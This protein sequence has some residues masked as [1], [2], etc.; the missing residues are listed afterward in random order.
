MT[1]LIL[2]CILHVA[3]VARQS[4]KMEAVRSAE[5]SVNFHRNTWRHIQ[6]DKQNPTRIKVNL[7]LWL[8]N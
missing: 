3:C 4:L 1:S 8:I 7:S 6:E 2:S 5:T